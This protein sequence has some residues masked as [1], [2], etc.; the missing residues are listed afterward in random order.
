MT[1]TVIHT[2]SVAQNISTPIMSEMSEIG[3]SDYQHNNNTMLP[4]SHK[5]SSTDLSQYS[6]SDEIDQNPQ[7]N[8]LTNIR[9]NFINQLVIGQLNINSLRNKFES[10]VHIVKGNIDIVIITETKLDMSFPTNH[11]NMEGYF[12]PFRADRSA[13][14]G[15]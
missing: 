14:G 8:T 7:N 6:L 2:S 4:P 9:R 15:G 11:F 3:D 13:N 12:P 1:V 5:S 10:L